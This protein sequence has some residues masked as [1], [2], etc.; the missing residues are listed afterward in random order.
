[1]N[2]K[3]TKKAPTI[4]D[5]KSAIPAYL[6]ATKEDGKFIT[7]REKDLEE[8]ILTKYFIEGWT[9]TQI[10]KNYG[11][12]KSTVTDFINDYLLHNYEDDKVEL[13]S[14]LDSESH[15]GIMT[16]FF[17]NVMFLA[18]ESALNAIFARKLREAIADSVATKGVLETA[19]DRELMLA[20]NE[21]AQRTEKYGNLASKQMDT[22]VKLMEQVLDKQ[23]EV[24][25][26][27]VLFDLVQKLEPSVAEKLYRA[28]AEDEYA[29]A[30]LESLSGENLL[31]TFKARREGRI[32]PS[33][34]NIIEA[35]EKLLIE[36]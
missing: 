36:E 4:I 31:K 34:E 12:S 2:S 32:S 13:I 1:M 18:K 6:G 29:R 28:L 33:I 10:S 8:E 19:K 26:V 17:A 14:I 20:W 21:V 3:K 25:F 22:Y 11:I 5:H 9:A 27:K 7:L 16:T 23:R 15:L 35:Q 24:A 30:V